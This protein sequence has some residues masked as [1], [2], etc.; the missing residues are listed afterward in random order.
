MFK[1]LILVRH[2]QSTAN[3]GLG[4]ES[5]VGDAGVA[6]TNAGRLQAEGLGYRLAEKMGRDTLEKDTLF[7]RSPYKR[8][9]QTS[10]SMMKGAGITNYHF[11][12]APQLREIEYGYNHEINPISLEAEKALRKKHGWF[13]YRFE[14]GESPADVY[15]RADLWLGDMIRDYKNDN[16]TEQNVIV[17]THGTT[18]RCLLMRFMKLS[19]EQF[20]SLATPPNAGTFIIC[21]K[22]LSEVRNPDFSYK[23]WVAYGDIPRYN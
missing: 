23:D 6:L 22:E 1:R 4:M 15:N 17:H 2:G 3:V 12:E 20:D 11:H 8:T 14:R 10:E 19:V 7:Y 16:R 13:Y 21:K 18:M 5:D 9:R